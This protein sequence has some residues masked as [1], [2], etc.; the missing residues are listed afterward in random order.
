[1]VDNTLNNCNSLSFVEAA[2]IL[3]GRLYIDLNNV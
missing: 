3:P 2:T 1:M